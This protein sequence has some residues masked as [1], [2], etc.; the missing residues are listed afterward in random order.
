MS[1][2]L[3]SVYNPAGIHEREFGAYDNAAEME[4]AFARVSEFNASLENAG[5]LLFAAGLGAP[6]TAVTVDP[7]GA[8]SDG[9]GFD[10]PYYL[11]GFWAIKVTGIDAATRIAAQAA[12]ACGQRVEVR[13][14]EGEEEEDVGAIGPES[15]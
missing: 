12:A 1:S 3:L 6:T 4:A 5:L 15:L 9:P 2:Y 13:V 10:A 7:D 8:L 11:G 14:M